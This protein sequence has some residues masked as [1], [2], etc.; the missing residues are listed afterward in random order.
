M[1]VF[2]QGNTHRC[3]CASRRA[4][5]RL[6]RGENRKHNVRKSN[7]NKST[8]TYISM[9]AS[10]WSLTEVGV[11]VGVFV[12]VDVGMLVGVFSQEEGVD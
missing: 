6:N 9:K 2:K 12:G 10:A 3:W 7:R 5:G 1:T 4:C 8:K 11:E